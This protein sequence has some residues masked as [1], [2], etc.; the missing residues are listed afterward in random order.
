MEQVK[1][2][3]SNTQV[4]SLCAMVFFLSYYISYCKLFLKA[5]LIVI[6]THVTNVL[7]SQF[8]STLVNTFPAV[9]DNL[10]AY[11]AVSDN[12]D[13]YP[14]V[15]DNLD[16]FPAVSDNLDAYPAVSDNLDAY[17]AVSDNFDAYPAVNHLLNAKKGK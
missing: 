10:Y 8:K 4:T 7:L 16:A 3:I 12:L 9:L 2:L 5:P 13:V 1:Q 15:S 17:P 14:A 6:F 11:P